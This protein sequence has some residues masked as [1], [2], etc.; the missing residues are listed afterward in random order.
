[1]R[2]VRILAAVLV[3]A[4]A[5]SAAAA[6]TASAKAFHAGGY[7]AELKAQQEGS[8]GNTF[9][10]E[11]GLAVKCKTAT[12]TGELSEAKEE[13]ELTPTYSECTAAGMTATIVLEGCKYRLSANANDLDIVC[14]A[15]KSIKVTALSGQCEALIGSQNNLSSVAYVLNE[16]AIET[17]SIKSTL[18]KVK[19]TKTKDGFLCP[20]SGT[21][22]KE[23][24]AL[25]G[26]VLMKAFY[27]AG[28]QVETFITNLC[29]EET[30]WP[31]GNCTNWESLNEEKLEE[32]WEAPN[33]ELPEAEEE[34]NHEPILF[35]HGFIGSEK[36]WS[37]MIGWFKADGWGKNELVNWKYQWWKSNIT[38]AGLIKT[39]V[40]AILK[41][42]KAA[43]VDIVT[44]S[45]GAL[46]SRYY[47][48]NLMGK[49]ELVDDWVSLGGPN[50]GTTWATVA[51]NC[52]KMIV[53]CAE[54]A[55]GSKFLTD[56]NAGSETPGKINYGTWRGTWDTVILPKTSVA[57]GGT[58]KNTVWKRVTHGGLHE[59]KGIYEEVRNFV[60]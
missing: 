15:G 58:A 9:T 10:A 53:A 37:T 24:G 13:I 23:D 8:E 12:L 38:T 59:T 6:S 20:F 43:K 11:G 29:S 60:K 44:H 5:F 49:V 22:V 31:E 7:T 39:K 26:Q 45:M 1:V 54:M 50:H 55:P 16:E 52:V 3:A 4:S 34:L 30:E 21:G 47:I 2:T 28:E 56:L 36:T 35:I 46:S 17:I 40:E 19:Y 51:K 48:K 41:A 14:P 27:G 57:L 33:E 18:S 25:S 42:T 32:E